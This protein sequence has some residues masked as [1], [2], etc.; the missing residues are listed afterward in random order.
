ME[1]VQRRVDLPVLQCTALL[2]ALCSCVSALTELIV[3][4]AFWLSGGVEL[5]MVIPLINSH[6]VQVTKPKELATYHNH[7]IRLGSNPEFRVR[8]HNCSPE[9]EVYIQ[10]STCGAQSGSEGLS[11]SDFIKMLQYVHNIKMLQY[12]HNITNTNSSKVCP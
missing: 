11:I 5:W 1:Q 2:L 10:K 7:G 9:K 3:H 6:A 8:F 12:V 4:N